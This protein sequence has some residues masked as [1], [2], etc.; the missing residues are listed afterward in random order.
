MENLLC[1]INIQDK[2]LNAIAVFQNFF[3]PQCQQPVQLKIGTVNIPHFSHIAHQSC[4]RL[5]AEGESML[6]LQGKIQLFEWLN[7]QGY[8]VEL[9]PYIKKTISTPRYSCD[10][11]AS[12]NSN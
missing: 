1:L 9:E 5:F 10:E 3:C 4:E 2:H 8:A 11:R 12:T 7:K 6:H